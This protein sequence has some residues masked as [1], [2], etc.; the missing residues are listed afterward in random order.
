MKFLEAIFT[1]AAKFG[2]SGK[3]LGVLSIADD[4][5]ASVAVAPQMV[6]ESSLSYSWLLF[7]ASPLFDSVDLSILLI[8]VW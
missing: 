7:F 3:T 6:E 1:V 5:L 4:F 8:V 2:F